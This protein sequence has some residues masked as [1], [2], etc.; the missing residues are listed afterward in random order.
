MVSHSYFSVRRFFSNRI[1][2]TQKFS[3]SP[4]SEKG[5]KICT[6]F[7]ELS[8]THRFLTVFQISVKKPLAEVSKIQIK[9]VDLNKN[10]IIQSSDFLA[11]LWFKLIRADSKYHQYK[12][13]NGY[14]QSKEIL[15]AN[16]NQRVNHSQIRSAVH[17]YCF[18]LA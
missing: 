5:V 14:F 11:K 3:R 13:I 17:H 7:L 16:K 8:T 12:L 4:M 10:T 15:I 9:K 2:R 18:L 6:L 1:Q